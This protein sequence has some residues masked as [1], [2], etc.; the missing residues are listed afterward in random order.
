MF[1]TTTTTTTIVDG[2]SYDDYEENSHNGTHDDA[3]N[4][5]QL[6]RTFLHHEKDSIII[7][8]YIV[9]LH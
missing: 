3:N 7:I 5:G 8:M 1:F 2:Y 9:N 6:P 4:T